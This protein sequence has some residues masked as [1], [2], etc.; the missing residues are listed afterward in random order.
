MRAGDH[1]PVVVVAPRKS[2]CLPNPPTTEWRCPTIMRALEPEV[3]DAVFAA[4]EPHLPGPSRSH[5]LGCHRPRTSDRLVFEL[6][7]VRLVTGCSWVT[8]ERLCGMKVSDTTA[9][10]R[11][12]E[13]VEAGVFAKLAEEAIRAYDKVIGLDLEEVAVDGSMHKVWI[14]TNG[15]SI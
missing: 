1:P 5:P 7:L 13:W 11:R 4:I 3:V 8:A 15:L 10:A 14:P 9:R 6:I 12:D 2:G